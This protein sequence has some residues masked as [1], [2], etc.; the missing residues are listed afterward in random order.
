MLTLMLM[1]HPGAAPFRS[2]LNV[3]MW[4]RFDG[5]TL[6]STCFFSA[7]ALLTLCVCL[8]LSDDHYDIS[9]SGRLTHSPQ[10]H[11]SLLQLRFLI[12]CLS[13]CLSSHHLSVLL[14]LLLF[15]AN[16]PHFTHCTYSSA[17]ISMA[18]DCSPFQC[19]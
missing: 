18:G 8:S 15:T 1:L 13:V 2:I 6:D 17:L 11:L 9:L 5:E 3:L 4:K 16:T 14:S 7:P 10:T 19:K 12:A